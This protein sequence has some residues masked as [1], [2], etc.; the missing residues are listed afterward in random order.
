MKRISDVEIGKLANEYYPGH[1]LDWNFIRELIQAQL[2]F[3]EKERAANTVPPEVLEAT[4]QL[5]IQEKVRE[6]S[7]KIQAGLTSVYMNTASPNPTFH[8]GSQEH[9][10]M[11][12][13]YALEKMIAG[14]LIPLLG[15]TQTGGE[16]RR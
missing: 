13:M 10:Y 12:R 16:Y 1:S 2:D 5:R 6:I 15:K 3:C 7:E 8:D 11:T 14:I 9:L 4:I